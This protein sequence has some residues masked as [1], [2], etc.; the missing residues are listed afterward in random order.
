M[1][2]IKHLKSSIFSLHDNVAQIRTSTDIRAHTYVCTRAQPIVQ[3][4]RRLICSAIRDY[5]RTKRTNCRTRNKIPARR[6]LNVRILHHAASGS[7]ESPFQAS[8][9]FHTLSHRYRL[10]AHR[11]FDPR[12]RKPHRACIC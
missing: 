12:L 5:C 8:H 4:S 11:V 7:M 10:R 6:Q 1:T 3:R 2:L 9:V